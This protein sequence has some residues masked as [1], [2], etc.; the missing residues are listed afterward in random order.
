MRWEGREESKNVIDSRRGRATKVGAG[1]GLGSLIIIGLA[2]F[3][4]QDP[5]A[6]LQQTQSQQAPPQ[7]QQTPQ[8]Q[9]DDQLASFVKVVLKDCEDVWNVLFP[10]QLGRNYKEP[11]MEIYSGRVNS[12]CG[13]GTAASGPFYCPGDDKVY[14]DLSFYQD[15]KNRFQAPGDFAMAYVVAHEVA[16]HV[17]NQLGITMEIQR[18]RGRIPVKE[19]NK[20]QV[21]LELQADFLAGVWAHHAQRMKGILEQG[22]IEEAMNAAH[23]IGDDRIQ[24]QSRGYV[25]PDS[26][27]HGTSEQRMRWFRKGLESGDLRLG[28]TFDV[29]DRLL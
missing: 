17:Q 28:D 9:A 8:S 18:K 27:T 1:L 3:F 15:L 6:I 7:T 24:M 4:G 26:F 21:R 16:H 2:L 19:Y 5:S 11:V 25:V 22:D 10:E 23:A 12:A 29:P 20:L 13:M 14:I